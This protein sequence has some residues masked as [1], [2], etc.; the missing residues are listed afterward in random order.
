MQHF[1]SF[2]II[3]HLYTFSYRFILPSL[4]RENASCVRKELDRKFTSL[5]LLQF[6]HHGTD[7]S[8]YFLLHCESRKQFWASPCS[9]ITFLVNRKSF[10][11]LRN[12]AFLIVALQMPMRPE[13][14]GW[15]SEWKNLETSLL[16]ESKTVTDMKS[17]MTTENK[18][19]PVWITSLLCISSK[20]WQQ[21]NWLY[22]IEPRG[23]QTLSKNHLHNNWSNFYRT[24]EVFTCTCPFHF[25]KTIQKWR[26]RVYS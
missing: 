25:D 17:N 2:L 10:I 4:L 20:R 23:V 21:R 14:A 22:K 6:G 3:A 7:F 15:H 13:T 16:Y 12:G 24:A 1:V 5:P 19:I 26:L 9:W 8:T 11:C 18:P